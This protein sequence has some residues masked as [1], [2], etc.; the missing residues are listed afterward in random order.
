MSTAA[1]RTAVPDD[2]IELGRVLSAHG[3]RGWVK[4]QPHSA[5]AETLL[6]SKIWW[7]QAPVAPAGTGALSRPGPERRRVL[8]CRPHGATLIAQIEGLDDRDV[9]QSL[10]GWS[11]LVPRSSF[12]SPEEDEY[13]WVD[14]IGCW[15][16]GEDDAGQRVLIGKVSDMSD[17]GAH[18]I[19][20][21]TRHASVDGEPV[22]DDK[23]RTQ[24]ALVPF[25]GAHVLKV[26]L[27]G[28][29]IVSDWPAEL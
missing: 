7:L 23:G 22:R 27:D 9:A 5:Q 6:S 14:L 19:M 13:Y 12:A 21:V 16:Y 18:A 3:V 8:F 11:I 1:G 29:T 4:I 10:K 15:V 24:E 25:V 17:N 20:H 26:D 28:R 2:L